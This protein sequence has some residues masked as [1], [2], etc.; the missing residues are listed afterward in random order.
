MHYWRN[1]HVSSE[2]GID[3]TNEVFDHPFSQLILMN[4]FYF[5]EDNCCINPLRIEGHPSYHA[6]ADFTTLYCELFELQLKLLP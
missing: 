2:R 6:L 4:N 3:M 1:I 5:S